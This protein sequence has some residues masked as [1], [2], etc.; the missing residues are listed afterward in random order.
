[1]L[2][3]NGSGLRYNFIE[4]LFS[5]PVRIKIAGIMMLPILILGISL[6]YWV[7]TGLS[8]WLSY[9]LSDER[10]RIAMEAGSRS[11]VLVT[12]LSTLMS[13][14]FTFLLMLT[15]T[16]PLLELRQV[17][18]KV[19]EGDLESRAHVRTRDE[20]GEVA[21]SVNQMID[22]L[23][24]SQQR[25][26]RTNRRLEAINRIAIAAGRGLG[27]KD[28]LGVSLQTVLEEMR[29]ESGWIY[30]KDQGDHPT[31]FVLAS[32]IGLPKGVEAHLLD[33]NKG[34]CTCDENILIGDANMQINVH[35]CASLEN[36]ALQYNIPTQYVSVPLD[37]DGQRIG[38][39][40]ML[41]SK[42]HVL[43]EN[44]I[45][46]LGTISQQLSDYIENAWLQI[47]LRE[48]EAT[49]QVLLNALVRAQEDERARLAR[50]LHDDA[51]QQLTSLLVHLKAFEKL[52]PEGELREKVANLCQTTSGTIERVRS[53][54]HRLRPAVLEELGLEAALR[55][56]A[57]EMLV[58]TDLE[59][60]CN[61][62]LN[63][64]RLPFEIETSLY[65]IAQESLTNIVN[66]AEAQCV[67]IELLH[68]PSAVS[69]QIKDDGRG[70][71]GQ[72][73]VS[74]SDQQRLGLISMQERA[75]MLGGSFLIE[76]S[77][78]LG[79]SVQVR[80]PVPPEVIE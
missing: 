28:L 30:L 44:D 53:L 72:F 25:L 29:F 31:K 5:V 15:L 40:N 9:L 61:L 4:I 57:G 14:L 42:D 27:L 51:G 69:L 48:K 60:E 56:L 79:T 68:L 52:T 47:S 33:A 43:S 80:I 8:D 66:H 54:S 58:T 74:K 55:T 63:D 18:Q 36:L 50:E 13:V 59:F 64:R 22:H 24:S 73:S 39:I 49:R 45:E 19:A 2:K 32:A 34:L 11:V 23:V 75:E 6:N 12:A 20:I 1:M 37:L 65:R 77:R 46:V 17:A 67:M 38:I 41:C 35:Q 78:G 26:E 3:I 21:E 62:N 7:R 71:G 76:T 10:V 70:F 16:K